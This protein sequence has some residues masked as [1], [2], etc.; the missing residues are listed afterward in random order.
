MPPLL[1]A[2]MKIV[3]GGG[4]VVRPGR[5]VCLVCEGCG[6]GIAAAAAAAAA[7]GNQ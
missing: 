5:L 3:G 1:S 4:G 2:L 6:R 7:G